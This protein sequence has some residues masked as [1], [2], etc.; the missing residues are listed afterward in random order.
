MY[1]VFSTAHMTTYTTEHHHMERSTEP[2]P[3]SFVRLMRNHGKPPFL[4]G[5]KIQITLALLMLE[6]NTRK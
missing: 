3:V 1:T 4:Q 6:L 2:T 5:I